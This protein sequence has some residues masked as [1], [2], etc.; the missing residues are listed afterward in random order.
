MIRATR[1]DFWFDKI[2]LELLLLRSRQFSLKISHLTHISLRD[3]DWKQGK[4]DASDAWSGRRKR[5]ICCV[6][7]AEGRSCYTS[8]QGRD[9]SRLY[10]SHRKGKQAKHPGETKRERDDNCSVRLR[11]SLDL[12]T[13]NIPLT[14]KA[15]F[16]GN[17]VSALK[18]KSSVASSQSW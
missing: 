17:Y 11:M 16:W 4:G 12:Y 6:K 3:S 15:K 13:R 9:I 2:K 10:C 1:L 14:Q 5:P 8:D 7:K 18:G